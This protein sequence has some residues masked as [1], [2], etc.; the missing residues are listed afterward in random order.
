[1][2]PICIDA[3]WRK[4]PALLSGF[5]TFW[6]LGWDRLTRTEIGPGDL[7][8]QVPDCYRLDPVFSKGPYGYGLLPREVFVG[9][10]GNIRR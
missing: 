3:H 4:V 1:M 5:L 6:L 10:C 9:G 2:E 7:V 8:P